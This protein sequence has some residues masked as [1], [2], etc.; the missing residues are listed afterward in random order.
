MMMMIGAGEQAAP[1]MPLNLFLLSTDTY[2]RYLW[3]ARRER[4]RRT[5]LLETYSINKVL[6]VL[7]EYALNV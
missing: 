5:D 7:L 1:V 3:L 4:R 6:A 2:T